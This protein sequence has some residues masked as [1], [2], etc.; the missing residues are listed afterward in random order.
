VDLADAQRRIVHFIDA[1]YNR[2]RLH[3]AI[4]YQT[5]VE[6]EA[7]CAAPS[8]PSTQSTAAATTTNSSLPSL[9]DCLS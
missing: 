8:T 7:Q 1:I 9:T 3:S 2:K 6:F 4:G 5:L